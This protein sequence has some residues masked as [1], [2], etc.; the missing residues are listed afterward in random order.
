MIIK[1]KEELLAFLL[2]RMS[3]HDAESVMDDV[4]EYAQQVSRER[5]L[6]EIELIQEKFK[7]WADDR[8]FGYR[9]ID[10]LD[11]IINEWIKN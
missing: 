4:D 1:L 10:K 7:E 5:T 8:D 11:E 3:T 6:Q 2:N 9:Y